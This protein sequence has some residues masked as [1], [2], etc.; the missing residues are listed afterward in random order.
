MNGLHN[1]MMLLR[2]SSCAFGWPRPTVEDAVSEIHIVRHDYETFSYFS[3]IIQVSVRF[4]AK[5]F[6]KMKGKFHPI[7]DHKS[8][9][10]EYKYIYTLSLTSALDEGGVKVTPCRFI[11]STAPV[12]TVEKDGQGPVPKWRGVEKRKPPSL[13]GVKVIGRKV[14]HFATKIRRDVWCPQ[15]VQYVLM[16]NGGFLQY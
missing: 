4:A 11:P 1:G 9:E 3:L 15:E 8:T 16:Q 10:E 13:A 2:Q 5:L 6:L 14:K 7:T 12:P